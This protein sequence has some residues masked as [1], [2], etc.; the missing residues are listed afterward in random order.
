MKRILPILCLLITLNAFS[1][2]DSKDRYEKLKALRVSYI[3]E[4]LDLTTQ[5]AEKFWPI[6]NKYEEKLHKLRDE[7]RSI[8]KTNRDNTLD[9]KLSAE[10]VTMHIKTE[11]TKAAL[12]KT[13]VSDL[14][15]ILS[16]EKIW[17]LIRSEEGF[18]RKLI[19]QY[20]HRHQRKESPK[21]NKP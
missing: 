11:E 19:E 17:K 5:E 16:S 6:Y 2:R 14:K 12:L 9:E 10:L 7:L 1:Q 4:R 13:L 3:T 8:I 21:K 18:R 20:R 15:P